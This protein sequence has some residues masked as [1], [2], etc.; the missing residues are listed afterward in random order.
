MPF[1]IYGVI[2]IVFLAAGPCLPERATPQRN[3]WRFGYGPERPH[4][5]R[6]RLWRASETVST[7]DG[8]GPKSANDGYGPYDLSLTTDAVNLTMATNGGPATFVE[9]PVPGSPR[10]QQHEPQYIYIYIHVCVCVCVCVQ[11]CGGM[12]LNPAAKKPEVMGPVC[13]VV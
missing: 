12:A 1:R 11:S 9:V 5:R 3:S 10:L 13:G 4:L 7:D 8:Y 6:R 2:C